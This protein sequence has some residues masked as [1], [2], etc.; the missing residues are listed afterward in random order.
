M[1]QEGSILTSFYTNA[2]VSKGAILLRGYNNG[3]RVHKKIQY[4]PYLFLPNKTGIYKALVNSAPLA[5]MDFASIYDAE[6][7]IETYKDTSNFEYHGLNRWQYLFLNDTYQG[8][9][10]YD[11]SKVKTAFLDIEVSMD[12]GKPNVAT[13]NMPVTA[14][15]VSDGNMYHV[16]GYGDFMTDDEL[17]E[18]HQ[19]KNERELLFSFL[20]VWNEIDFDIVTGWFVEGFD[21]PYLYQRIHD[22]ISPQEAAR[23]SPWGQVRKKKFFDKTGREVESVV[24]TGIAILDYLNLY[25]KFTQGRANEQESLGYISKKELGDS[26]VDYKELGYVD[27]NDLYARNHQL[28]IEYNIHDV[29]LVKKLDD[30]LKFLDLAMAIA[31]DAKINFEDSTSTVLLWDIIIHNKLL[32][33]NTVIPKQSHGHK[34]SA[35]AGAFVK[36]PRVGA[37]NWVESF[38]LASLYPHLMM[39]F[40]ISPET[41]IGVDREVTV[42]MI[43]ENS[44]EWQRKLAIA[45][46]NN[47]GI[48]GNGAMFTCSKK[49][50]MPE[51]MESYYEDRKKFKSMMIE[52]QKLAVDDPT[53]EDLKRKIIQYNGIQMAKKISINGAYGALSNAYFRHY[54]DDLAEA[55]TLSGQVAI[56]W[57]GNRVNGFLQKMMGTEYDYIIAQDT[58]SAFFH[59]DDIVKKRFGDKLPS[60]EEVVEFLNKFGDQV[61]QPVIKKCFYDLAVHMNAMEQKL[62]MKREKI[63]SRAIWTGAKRY[64][65]NIWDNEGVRYKKPK[66][67]MVGIEAVRASTPTICR[68]AIEEG[69]KLIL[70]QN[71]NG[72][73]EFMDKFHDTFVGASLSDI[74]RNSSVNGI[75]KYMKGTAHGTPPHVAGAIAYNYMLKVGCLDE[76]YSIIKDGDRVKFLPMKLPNPAQS[77]WISFPNAL[78]PKELGLDK[79][80]D[81]DALANIGYKQP[82]D[83]IASAGGMNIEKRATLED[84]FA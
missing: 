50:I 51:L 63:I 57:V 79:Y 12:G 56:Q 18:Y 19:C 53:N 74:A 2:Q 76:T 45:A 1:V 70:G 72:V 6:E 54:N 29:R 23:L 30:K 14:I 31:Y 10:D 41:F 82:L 27:L 67:K 26:K 39:Q 61:L 44:P 83:T 73:Y 68:G 11:L 7:F 62:L 48:A 66:F 75:Q 35:I 4:K 37:Y 5:K 20:R 17:I 46:K 84:F 8:M 71:Q 21:L 13:A 22:L 15:T 25:R 40:N 33:R 3:H 43:L 77:K 80:V 47:Y 24:I 38:D 32:E 55:I 49:G 28:Y 64:I 60:D 42:Q 58:D 65:M 36:E 16:F 52:C 81:Y 34:A 59:L 9:V 69:A 78:L